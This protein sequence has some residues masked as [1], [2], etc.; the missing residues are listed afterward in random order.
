VFFC[1]HASMS[2]SR[3]LMALPTLC[4]VSPHLRQFSRTVRSGTDNN[5]ATSLHPIKRLL[6]PIA[7]LTPR[8]CPNHTGA[9]L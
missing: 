4:A 7:T 3:N 6:P 1:S 8:L 9:V 2:R 5:S